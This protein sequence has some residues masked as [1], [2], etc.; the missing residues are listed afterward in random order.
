M[1]CRARGLVA[2]LAIVCCAGVWSS[3]LE[4]QQP[5]TQRPQ[6][7]FVPVTDLPQQDQLPAAPLLVAA[8]IVVWLTLLV[9]LWTI[10]RRLGKVGR[11]LAALARRLGEHE[12]QARR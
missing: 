10:W 12:P 3:V 4:A 7:E 8:Y 5:Q 6:D 9:Y 2:A 1:G 11:E